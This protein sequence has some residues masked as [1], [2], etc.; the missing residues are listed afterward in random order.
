M[1]SKASSKSKDS[2][3]KA[4]SKKGDKPRRAKKDKDAPK[5]PLSGYLFFST[6]VRGKIKDANPDFGFGDITKEISRQWKTL[7]ATQRKPFDDKAEADKARYEKEKSAYK[8]AGGG[9]K[10][11]GAKKSKKEESEDDQ[12]EDEEESDEGDE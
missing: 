7:S 3:R 6:E 12:D 9:S 8:V 4:S 10:G 5:K 2:K 11:K 1:S